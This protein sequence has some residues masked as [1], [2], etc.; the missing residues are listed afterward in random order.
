MVFMGKGMA[1]VTTRISVLL[2]SYFFCEIHQVSSGL[3]FSCRWFSTCNRSFVLL[4]YTHVLSHVFLYISQR[5]KNTI[6]YI[7]ARIIAPHYLQHKRKWC[8]IQLQR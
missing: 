3:D 7:P 5:G 6:H 8:T 1:T 4:Y 2:C